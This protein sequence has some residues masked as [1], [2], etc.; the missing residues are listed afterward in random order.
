MPALAMEAAAMAS[1][2]A[3]V[4]ALLEGMGPTTAAALLA[5]ALASLS[6]LDPTAELAR[7]RG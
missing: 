7:L 5:R 4:A 3:L 6:V 2:E 1:G